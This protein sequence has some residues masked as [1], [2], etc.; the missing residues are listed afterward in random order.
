MLRA[1]QVKGQMNQPLINGDLR[2]K[3]GTIEALMIGTTVKIDSSAIVIHD[4]LLDFN[5]F[6][7]I[8]PNKQRL[9]LLGTVDFASFSAIKMDASVQA[10]NFQ[11]MKVKENTETMV[12]GKVFVDLSATLKG[13]VVLDTR[14]I[15]F[16]DGTYR[17]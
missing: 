6:G 1:F 8:A 11:A 10:K 5:H 16:L 17:L 12:Y 3:D 13:K 14:H 2:F 7:L 4:N 9:E 15:C